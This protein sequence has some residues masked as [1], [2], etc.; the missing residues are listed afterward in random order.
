MAETKPNITSEP[1]HPNE[2][3]IAKINRDAGSTK[4]D[5]NAEPDTNVVA[6]P[7]GRQFG[8]DGKETSA[9]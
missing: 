2:A 8:I 6:T 5:Y 4:K 3:K 1:S 7:A 9:T